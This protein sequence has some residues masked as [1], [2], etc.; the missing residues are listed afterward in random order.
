MKAYIIQA[1]LMTGALFF[2]S[3]QAAEPQQEMIRVKA[4]FKD[5]SGPA[6]ILMLSAGAEKPED[7]RE[8][9]KKLV[10]IWAP[11]KNRGMEEF[12]KAVIQIIHN[13]YQTYTVPG[14]SFRAQ[15]LDQILP[16]TRAQISTRK[17]EAA[18]LFPE[19]AQAA[20]SFTMPSAKPA[21]SQVPPAQSAAEIV[22]IVQGAILDKLEGLSYP[23]AAA[24]KAKILLESLGWQDD[25]IKNTIVVNYIANRWKGL[26]YRYAMARLGAATLLDTPAARQIRVQLINENKDRIF[27]DLLH[28][29]IAVDPHPL[30]DALAIVPDILITY[31]Q[32]SE[33]NQQPLSRKFL[34]ALIKAGVDINY[35]EIPSGQ[36][37]LIQCIDTGRINTEAQSLNN[38]NLLFSLV[39]PIDLNQQDKNRFS[40]LMWAAQLN[41]PSIVELLLSK[42]ADPNL[43][44]YRGAN[45][46]DSA[47]RAG[48]QQLIK[49]LLAAGARPAQTELPAWA[50]QPQAGYAPTSGAQGA[51][52]KATN[53]DEK[54]H[55]IYA[56]INHHGQTLAQTAEDVRKLLQDF[57]WD[58]ANDKLRETIQAFADQWSAEL[59]SL[60]VITQLGAATLLNLPATLTSRLFII[61]ANED[62]ILKAVNNPPL[63]DNPESLA[64]ALAIASDIMI[65]YIRVT[66]DNERLLSK[67]FLSA[68][69][70]SGIDINYQ[71]K[72]AGF[73]A[74][75]Q[76]ILNARSE[77]YRLDNI[78]ILFSLN[79][80]IDLNKQ[81]EGGYTALSWAT[82]NEFPN[83][84]KLLLEKGADP[85]IK[86]DIGYNVFDYAIMNNNKE[87]IQMLL[88][89][90]I[91]PARIQVPA[92]AQSQES[93]YGKQQAAA[94]AA[95]QKQLVELLQTASN[96]ITDKDVT[97]IISF[98]PDIIATA[99]KYNKELLNTIKT[100]LA[101]INPAAK[102]TMNFEGET[103]EVPA[104]VFID[105]ILKEIDRQLAL[106]P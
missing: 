4:A 84:V 58:N 49:I 22:A 91:K 34:L 100:V 42:G 14:T 39:V 103:I 17:K 13:A 76:C 44:D 32:R 10:L 74:L 5:P 63:L 75:I 77:N 99:P 54:W 79:V 19:F 35:Q 62:T 92:W 89:R 6:G 59:K 61:R 20:P 90:G 9:W 95:M 52:P 98:I 106:L 8:H 21:A 96:Q 1:F 88:D 80:P 56:A 7:I 101:D 104:E 53:D 23:E 85:L 73:T 55:R 97:D 3:L 94:I 40:A 46:L 45:A 27:A 69:I 29:N 102:A 57:S 2:S 72:P 16:A 81:S 41:Y 25:V 82:N 18:A 11:D 78:K 71:I 43:I 36:T 28:P 65:S 31:I 48:R 15:D 93:E 50:Q 66:N 30:A 67:R 105:P 47:I 37:A 26:A 24:A 70:S 33:K 64:A 38:I 68:L 86:S 83:V 12:A 87:I 60:Y 51:M